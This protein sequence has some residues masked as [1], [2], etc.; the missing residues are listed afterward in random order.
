MAISTN[1]K[2]TIYRNL[3]GDTGPGRAIAPWTV[4]FYR[5]QLYNL[6]STQKVDLYSFLNFFFPSQFLFWH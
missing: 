4:L 2:P 6:N 5:G 3:Y 1:Q